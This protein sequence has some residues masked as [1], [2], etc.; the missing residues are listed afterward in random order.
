MHLVGFS[1]EAAFEIIISMATVDT[2]WANVLFYGQACNG[3][4]K[5]TYKDKI[6]P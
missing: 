1:G 4:I 5:K 6:F 2:V 3:N